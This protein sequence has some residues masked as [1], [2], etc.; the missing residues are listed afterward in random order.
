MHVTTTCIGLVNN[1]LKH[2]DNATTIREER[3]PIDPS[4]TPFF[5]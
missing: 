4:P 3:I 5:L 1:T 2:P